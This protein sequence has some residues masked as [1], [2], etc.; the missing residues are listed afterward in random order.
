MTKPQNYIISLGGSLIIPNDEINWQYLKKFRRLILDQLKADKRFFLVAGGGTTARKYSQAANKVVKI[1][2][3]DLDWLGIHSSRLNAHL[4]RTIFRDQAHPEIIKN[5][6]IH[7]D[8]DKNVVVGGGWKPGW[9][10]DYVAT[11]IAQ[12]YE[13]EHVI[14]LTNIDYVYDKDPARYP[15]AQKIKK[16]GWKDFRKLVGNK[17][18]PGLNTPFDPIA[19]K[20]AEQLDLEV[21]LMNGNKLANLRKYLNGENFQGTVIKGV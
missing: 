5:P 9:S 14:N 10:T 12:E 13:V 20:K 11:M 17:W 15:D 1:A 16:T 19:S 4:I 8:T 6:T 7:M 21:V 18:K 3:D 2:P